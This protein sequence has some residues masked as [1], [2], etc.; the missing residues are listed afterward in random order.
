LET[1]ATPAS[2]KAKAPEVKRKISKQKIKN[3]I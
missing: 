1:D 3:L 2:N